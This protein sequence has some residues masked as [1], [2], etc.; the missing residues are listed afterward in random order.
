MKTVGSASINYD[1][2]RKVLLIQLGSTVVE[3]K[4][5]DMETFAELCAAFGYFRDRFN[6]REEVIRY[7]SIDHFSIPGDVLRR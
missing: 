7:R 6:S 4:N 5:V 1:E 2:D 3:F